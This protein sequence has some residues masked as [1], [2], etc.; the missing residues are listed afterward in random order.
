MAINTGFYND[1]RPIKIDQGLTPFE[2]EGQRL[3]ISAGRNKLADYTKDQARKN[4]L[5]GLVKRS[6][7]TDGKIDWKK[8]STG[9]AQAGF[10]PESIAGRNQENSDVESAIDHSLKIIGYLAQV[11]GAAKDQS[12]WDN[13]IDIVEQTV[14]GAS[15]KIPKQYNP[16]N[17][18]FVLNQAKTH[19]DKLAETRQAY[20]QEKE[21]RLQQNFDTTLGYR[22]RND[23]LNRAVQMRGQDQSALN[24]SVP[25]QMTIGQQYDYDKKLKE[26]ALAK[27]E[28]IANLKDSTSNIDRLIDLQ[29]KTE[30][31]PI[32]GSTPIS[33][34]RKAIPGQD[35][36]NLSNLEKGYAE[37]SLKM[38]GALKQGGTTLGALSEKEGEWLRDA[39]ESIKTTGKINID[40]LNRGKKLAQ[41]QISRIS[42]ANN[43]P[44]EPEIQKSTLNNIHPDKLKEYRDEYIRLYGA[45]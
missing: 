7:T 34:I 36:E 31:G 33:Y 18:S 17:Q 14:P 32:L 41:D 16:N 25:P 44:I 26:D 38:I 3:E 28:V 42:K 1:L 9:A 37:L 10:A 29:S 20:L 24:R 21:Q 5:E 13:A 45:P 23:E 27:Q 35:A 40:M 15:E 43:I 4:M 2:M 22:Q 11:T 39:S 8:Y 19:A 6:V 12:S 30:T